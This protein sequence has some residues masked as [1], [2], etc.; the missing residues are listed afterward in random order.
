VRPIFNGLTD[1]E[2]TE[3]SFRAYFPDLVRVIDLKN[4]EA[5]VAAM[6]FAPVQ[7][8]VQNKELSNEVVARN[9]ARITTLPSDPEA[10]AS[11]SDGEK[12][13][14]EKNPRAAEASFKSV[15]AKYPNQP[16][17]WYGLGMV[18]VLDH[19]AERAKEVFGRLTTGQYAASQDPMVMAWSHIYLA[20]IFEEEG[21]LD[22]AKSEYQAVLSVQGAPTQ[23]QQAA[24]KGLG[25]LDL[26]KPTEPA[27]KRM[28][29]KEK[30]L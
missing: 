11:L 9:R 7:V 24:Q 4:E 15:L 21:Q 16:R 27:V 5:R 17:A 30:G 26:R 8:V 6:Q 20:R 22:K 28:K 12:K 1:Y 29:E 13:L 18:A 3:P 25:D 23:A 14:F 10:I 2:K 19:D